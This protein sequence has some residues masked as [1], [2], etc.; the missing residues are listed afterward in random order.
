MC[1]GLQD[2]DCYCKPTRKWKRLGCEAV[3]SRACQVVQTLG[4]AMSL[5][6]LIHNLDVRV[7]DRS[8]HSHDHPCRAGVCVGVLPLL[9]L[10]LC[11]AWGLAV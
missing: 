3:V 9:Q 2:R 4:A 7:E 10:Q 8:S 5:C 6:H 1:A 11:C